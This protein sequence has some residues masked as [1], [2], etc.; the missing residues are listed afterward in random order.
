[1]TGMGGMGNAPAINPNMAN[2]MRNNM[3]SGM[4]GMGMGNMIGMGGMGMMGNMMGMGGMGG[5]ASG[6]MGSPPPAGQGGF[7]NG[8]AMGQRNVSIPAAH[9]NF[10]SH[11]SNLQDL[12]RRLREALLRCVPVQLRQLR[13]LL[14][15]N[16]VPAH[17]DTRHK[18]LL[19]PSRIEEPEGKLSSCTSRGSCL[20]IFSPTL[21]LRANRVPF[22]EATL[23]KS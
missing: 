22:P 2:M 14:P 9:R 6:G 23:P 3:G 21:R 13:L 5:M 16:K 1:M 15:V 18:E 20:C 11:A 17:N 4:G 10:G 8:N 19:G 7:Q 12:S